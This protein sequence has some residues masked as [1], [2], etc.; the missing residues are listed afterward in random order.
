LVRV[1]VVTVYN[2]ARGIGVD[3]VDL[4]VFP[5]VSARHELVEGTRRMSERELKELEERIMRM[6]RDPETSG[7]HTKRRRAV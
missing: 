3:V 4:L 7:R 6:V 2:V 5:G 1:N